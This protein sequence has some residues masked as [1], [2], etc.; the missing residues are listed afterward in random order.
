LTGGVDG[1]RYGDKRDS[2]VH[3]GRALRGT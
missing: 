1:W 3:S 2:K